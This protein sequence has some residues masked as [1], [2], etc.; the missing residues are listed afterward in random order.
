[1]ALELGVAALVLSGCPTGERPPVTNPTQPTAP[2]SSA[3]EAQARAGRPTLLAGVES[4][5]DK[6][7]IMKEVSKQLG[8]QCDYCHDVADFAAPSPNKTIANYMFAHYSV[9]LQMRGGGFVS[10]GDCHQ[11]TAKLVGDRAD[12]ER[13]KAFMKTKMQDPFVQK[14]GAAVECATCH[15]DKVDRPFLPR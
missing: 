12:R 11:G 10:C 7:T 6:K 1:L 8:V 4:Q 15:G 9:G 5:S 13:V 14:G 3:L 2:T